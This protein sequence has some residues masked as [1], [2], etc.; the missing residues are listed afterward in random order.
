MV[1]E[2]EEGVEADTKD[3]HGRLRVREA[4][5]PPCL[6]QSLIKNTLFSGRGGC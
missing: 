6:D 3:E 4:S 5:A 1:D 2:V